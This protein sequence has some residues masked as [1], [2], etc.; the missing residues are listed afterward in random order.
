MF[1]CDPVQRTLIRGGGMLLVNSVSGRLIS[2][3]RKFFVPSRDGSVTI[4]SA[5]LIKVLI[6]EANEMLFH[7]S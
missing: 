1:P 7:A 4:S 3:E 6:K 2:F 5:S